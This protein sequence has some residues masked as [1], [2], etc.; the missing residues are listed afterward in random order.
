M[1]PEEADLL[2]EEVFQSLTDSSDELNASMESIQRMMGSCEAVSN[3][4]AVAQSSGLEGASFESYVRPVFQA[5]YAGTRRE[6]FVDQL[7]LSSQES[8]GK[9]LKDMIA[10][11]IR[12]IVSF[13]KNMVHFMKTLDLG[14]EILRRKL[15]NINRRAQASR[16]KSVSQ[17]TITL[18]SR[19]RFMRVGRIFATDPL[20]YHGELQHLATVLDVLQNDYI[21]HLAGVALNLSQ[22]VDTKAGVVGEA[23]LVEFIKRIKF[24]LYAS[25]LKMGPTPKERFNREN[26]MMTPPLIGGGSIFYMKQPNLAELKDIRF[27]GFMYS[28]TERLA[29]RPDDAVEFP[30]LSPEQIQKI[31]DAVIAILDAL[32]KGANSSARSKISTTSSFLE[33]LLKE[34]E[35]N[36]MAPTSVENVRRVTSGISYWLGNPYQPLAVNAMSVIRASIQYCGQSL[37]SYR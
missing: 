10:A 7:D 17:P 4:L 18:G 20:K 30:T 13:F 34:I 32:T 19:T 27:Y 33:K 21:P 29:I 14:S 11:M 3:C 31:P 28:T 23:A 25:K 24:D 5:V 8:A 9:Y 35:S 22:V 2:E 36:D 12:A 15:I 37:N 16:G 26:V 1:L 6:D